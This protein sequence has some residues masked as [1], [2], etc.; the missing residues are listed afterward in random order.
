MHGI[1]RTI[2]PMHRFQFR[3]IPLIATC[4]LMAVFLRL[5]WWQW[6]KAVDVEQQVQ[7]REAQ[8]ATHPALLGAQMVDAK[9][10]DGAD[11]VVRGTFEPDGQFFLDNQQHLGRPGLHVI[12]PLRIEGSSVR[13]LVNRGWVGWGSSRSELPNV[14]V[15]S[16]RV[17]VHGRAVLPMGKAPA[18]VSESVGNTD[19]LRTRIRLDDIQAAANFPVQPI[20]ILMSPT[21][22]S[23]GLIKEWPEVTNKAPMHK[24]YAAQ[25]FLMALLLL[26]FFVRSSYRKADV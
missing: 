23:D 2:F 4:A 21:V 1:I 19:A 7:T 9:A 10:L 5:G 14:S 17:E 22:P 12:T 11:V 16:G 20:V 6:H 15:P 3:W 24:G 26:V 13:V 25:W 18:F 8:A